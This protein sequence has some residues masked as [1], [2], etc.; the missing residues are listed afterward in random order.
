MI[1]L[2]L[3]VLILLLII[4]SKLDYYSNKEDFVSYTKCKS[5][6]IKNLKK[7]IYDKYNIDYKKDGERDWDIYLPCGYNNVEN[8]LKKIK[9]SHNKQVIFG[10]SGCDK[11]ISKNS[12]WSLLENYYGRNEAKNIMPESFVLNNQSNRDLFKTSFNPKKMYVIKKNLQRKKGIKLS[13][14]LNEILNVD[15]EYKVVQEF[16][17]DSYIINKRVLNLRIY[18]MISCKNNEVKFYLHKLGKCLYSAKDINK[19]L[20]DFDSRI[21]NS[22]KTEKNIYDNNPLTLNELKD[23]L[24]KKQPNSG[25]YLFNNI[26]EL[27]KKLCSCIKGNIYNSNNL[28][29]NMTVQMF[30]V[31]VIFDNN[32]KPYILEINKGPDMMPKD[33]KDRK[34]KYKVELDMLEKF[35]LVE[36]DDV[37]YTNGFKYFNL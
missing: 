30:G 31:D 36:I 10:I 33:D 18:L 4:Y 15:K 12:L 28:I 21:T 32:M 17:T 11:I 8:E 3:F 20:L 24:N 22:Y 14:N 5:K 34:I 13:N 37:R 19:N 6:E 16:I 7:E 27:F 29:N 25:S 23:Y 1:V 26:E 9:V 35:D 2:F